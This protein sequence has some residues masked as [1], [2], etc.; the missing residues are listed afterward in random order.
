MSCEAL[1]RFLSITAVC[2]LTALGGWA[3]SASAEVVF[4]R[5]DFDA[6]GDF[7]GSGPQATGG[8]WDPAGVAVGSGS[9]ANHNPAGNSAFVGPDNGLDG[10]VKAFRLDDQ[11]AAPPC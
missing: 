8:P 3:S 6:A 1:A 11:D 9:I 2:C 10:T 5:A 7:T 4:L